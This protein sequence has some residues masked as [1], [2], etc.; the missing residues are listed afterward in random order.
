MLRHV[1]DLVDRSVQLLVF[2]DENPDRHCIKNQLPIIKSITGQACRGRRTLSINPTQM[3]TE[4]V[5]VT[6]VS[7]VINSNHSVMADGMK[8]FVT[9]QTYQPFHDKE[10]VDRWRRNHGLQSDPENI[11][12]PESMYEGKTPGSTSMR[13]FQPTADRLFRHLFSQRDLVSGGEHPV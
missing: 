6:D 1:Y 9:L 12:G 3:P 11:S 10:T 8:R 2:D 4:E 7:L 5:G 13:Q